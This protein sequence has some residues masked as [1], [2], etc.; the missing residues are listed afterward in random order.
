MS[1]H[2]VEEELKSESITSPDSICVD[3]SLP[4]Y[5][6]VGTDERE[7]NKSKRALISLFPKKMVK[8]PKK[9]SDLSETDSEKFSQKSNI[10]SGSNADTLLAKEAKVKAE[11]VA[12]ISKGDSSGPAKEVAFHKVTLDKSSPKCQKD[13]LDKVI[14]WTGEKWIYAM[15]YLRTGKMVKA[16]E[17][18]SYQ[19]SNIDNRKVWVNDRR[20]NIV[21][22]KQI[23]EG[24]ESRRRRRVSTKNIK[25][26]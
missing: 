25:K 20:E 6:S 15:E 21:F 1:E 26:G 12:K 23:P 14:G 7:N 10:G 4:G 19:T 2:K 13:V 9:S 24:K 17:R 18:F 22:R 11:K 5:K 16:R 8:K 3:K